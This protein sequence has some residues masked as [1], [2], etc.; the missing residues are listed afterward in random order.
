MEA[1]K[2]QKS[3]LDVMS[4]WSRLLTQ[5]HD[6]TEEVYSLL[7]SPFILGTAFS[8][9]ENTAELICEKLE[10]ENLIHFTGRNKVTYFKMGYCPA[11]DI[12]YTEIRYLVET[13]QQA[14]GY[15]GVYRGCL[16][17][18][19]TDWIYH[20]KEKY[21]DV[22][23]SYLSDK[24]EE[25][26]FTLFYVDIE[27]EKGVDV[28]IQYVSKY[29]RL[30]VIDLREMDDKVYLSYAKQLLTEKNILSEEDT[31]Q[32]LL[33]YISLLRKRASFNGFDTIRLMCDEIEV[34][35]YLQEG[36]TKKPL[37]GGFIR[38]FSDNDFSK[39]YMSEKSQSRQIGFSV[40]VQE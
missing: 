11:S 9:L 25:G 6:D 33:D 27:K 17:L 5:F 35:Y 19:L 7:A 2:S 28:L 16:I 3:V 10:S 24:K 21:F 1:V 36:C 8:E 13:L 20:E 34:Q 18:E 14:A 31:E 26:I 15:Y 38:A 23:L 40:R 29:F 37:S 4:E 22:L 32:E 12:R 30:D 39:R